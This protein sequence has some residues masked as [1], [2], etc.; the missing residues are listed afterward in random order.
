MG[1]GRGRYPYWEP[2]KDVRKLQARSRGNH[3]LLTDSPRNWDYLHPMKRGLD[4]NP[5]WQK[6]EKGKQKE[7]CII[8]YEHM[9][10]NK[11]LRCVDTIWAT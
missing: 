6:V 3:S 10:P 11:C 5:Q 9:T 1:W 8:P 7:N 2:R 4:E